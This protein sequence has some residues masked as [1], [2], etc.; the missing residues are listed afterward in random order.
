MLSAGGAPKAIEGDAMLERMWHGAVSSIAAYDT[1]KSSPTSTTMT[2]TT[3]YVE[4]ST[5]S[6]KSRTKPKVGRRFFQHDTRNNTDSYTYA[7]GQRRTASTFTEIA[8]RQYANDSS[9]ESE[10]R[11]HSVCSIDHRLPPTNRRH[12]IDHIATD[13]INTKL[14]KKLFK[15]QRKLRLQ[16][17]ALKQQQ[18]ATSSSSSVVATAGARAP[19]PSSGCCCSCACSTVAK[20]SAGASDAFHMHHTASHHHHHH[21]AREIVQQRIPT[22]LYD[23]NSQLMCQGDDKQRIMINAGARLLPPIRVQGL[24]SVVR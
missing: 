2:T 9:L 3:T 10:P 22:V 5:A 12:A 16:T 4:N 21:A 8:K 14:R 6:K 13:I 20:A 11:L 18:Y 19:V 7:T 24:R 15:I 17:V 23:C 1:P